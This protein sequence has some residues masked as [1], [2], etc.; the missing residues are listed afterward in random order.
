MMVLFLDIIYKYIDID[1]N[2][3]RYYSENM[4]FYLNYLNLWISNF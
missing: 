2:L 3:Y 4:W 1:I